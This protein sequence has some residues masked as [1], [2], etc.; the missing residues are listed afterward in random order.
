MSDA[1]LEEEVP[2]DEPEETFVPST[3]A[4]AFSTKKFVLQALLDKARAV[5]PSRDVMPVLK[6]FQLEVSEGS[7]RVVATDLELSVVSTT[8]MVVVNQPDVAVFPGKRLYDIVNE[9]EDGDLELVVRDGRAHIAVGRTTWDLMLMDGSEYP[10]LPD[11]DEVDLFE[12]DRGKFLGSLAAVRYAAATDTVRPS[13]M[14]IDVSDGKMRA[15]D[16]VRFQQADLGQALPLDFQIPI[17]AVDDLAK[18]LRST[19]Q[20]MLQIGETDNHL[21]FRIAGDIFIANKLTVAFPDVEEILLKPALAN[22]EKLYVDRNDL[23][24]AIKRVRITAD[25]ETN[26]I[27]LAIA[28]GL[29]IVRSKDKYGN[30]ASEPIDAQWELPPRE[31]AVNHEYLSQMLAM[32]DM[33]SCQFLL[34]PSTKTRPCPLLLRDDESGTLGVLNQLRADWI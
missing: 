29:I 31:I 11:I 15:A 32:A 26:A 19:D 24:A 16:G 27:V 12:V 20:N 33:K 2:E 25:N 28:R 8:Q 14:M 5:L 18:L 30:Q 23:L 6:N 7:M 3:S 10:P 17:A 13:L 9:A 1:A 34:G 21:V 4:L 22:N